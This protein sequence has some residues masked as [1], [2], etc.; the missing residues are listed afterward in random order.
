M[1]GRKWWKIELARAWY[2]VETFDWGCHAYLVV[3]EAAVGQ[4]LPCEQ[5]GGNIHN[6]HAAAVVE[7]ND[8]PIDNDT[9]VVNE[10]FHS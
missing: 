2:E 8:I 10:N 9:H 1:H 3:W 7:I 6:P 5:D 4:T